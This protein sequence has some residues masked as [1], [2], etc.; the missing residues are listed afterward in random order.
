[1][2]TRKNVSQRVSVLDSLSDQMD[3]YKSVVIIHRFANNYYWISVI[4]SNIGA[5]SLS[6]VYFEDDFLSLLNVFFVSK[7]RA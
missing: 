5:A 3:I 4:L 2:L 7:R 6:I 1:M